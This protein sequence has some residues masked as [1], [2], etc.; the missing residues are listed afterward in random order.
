MHGRLSQ[1]PVVKAATADD[2]QLGA[3]LAVLVT[4]GT[5]RNFNPDTGTT[6]SA[7][8]TEPGYPIDRT[9]NG[10]LDD[11]G[12]SNWVSGTK[13]AQS[14]LTYQYAKPH[15]V[16]QVTVRFFRDGTTSWAQSMQVQVRGTDG[17]WVAAPGW[18]TAR[19]VASPADEVRRN[20]PS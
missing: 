19:P 10:V 9:R 7:S 14:T 5:L 12:W 2:G 20:E 15:Q 6:A 17:A 18:E 11:K 16:E 8:S 3:Q 4:E 13:P 1:Q